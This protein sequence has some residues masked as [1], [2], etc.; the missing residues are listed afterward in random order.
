MPCVLAFKLHL[1]CMTSSSLLWRHVLSD[2]HVQLLFPLALCLCLAMVIS[3]ASWKLS[4]PLV[5]FARRRAD[6]ITAGQRSSGGGGAAD[7]SLFE[8][9]FTPMTRAFFAL[10]AVLSA[11]ALPFVFLLLVF[12]RR[13]FVAQ[14]QVLPT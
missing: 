7:E 3:L 2:H 9:F 13:K 4:A 6:D 1:F 14:Q 11:S 12:A 10:I 5:D 8:L